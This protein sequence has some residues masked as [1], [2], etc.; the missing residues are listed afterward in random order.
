MHIQTCAYQARTRSVRTKHHMHT[1]TRTHTQQMHVHV[2]T[3]ACT[4]KEFKTPDL[5]EFN[6]E[7]CLLFSS[8]SPPS[9]GRDRP[10]S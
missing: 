6:K 9:V 4:H 3:H 10:C 2:Q 8:S 1:Y 7:A 5:E